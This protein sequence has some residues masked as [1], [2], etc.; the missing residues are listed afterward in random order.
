MATV[1]KR[2]WTYKGVTKEKWVLNYTDQ[3]GQR[4]QETFEK[5]KDADA[6]RVEVE[7]QMVKGSHTA[8]R[9]SVTFEFACRE[10]LKDVQR[11][12]QLGDVTGHGLRTQL[13]RGRVCERASFYRKLLVDITSNDIQDFVDDLR[14]SYSGHY[15]SGV[16]RLVSLILKF[17]CHSRREWLRANVL[18]SDPV[19]LPKYKKRVAV[20]SKADLQKLFDA[21]RHRQEGETLNTFVNR[22]AF[23]AIAALGGLRPGE[24][25]GLQWENI[26][27][28]KNILHV[29]NSQSRYDGLKTPKTESGVRDVPLSQP[30]I[31]ALQEVAFY[32]HLRDEYKAWEHYGRAK[33]NAFAMSKFLHRR[34]ETMA[35]A[36]MA[37]RTGYVFLNRDGDPMD[38]NGSVF[39]W[40][41]LMQKAGLY[42]KEGK[43][44][45]FTMHALRHA[46]ASLFIDF[47]LPLMNVSKL[48]GHANVS[49][50]TNVYGHLFPEDRRA[51]EVANRIAS[52][53]SATR[54]Q[55]ERVTH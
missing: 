14:A 2:P 24:V 22:K 21:T 15:V 47:G 42:D 10:Y 5:R 19:T 41:T 16:F 49:T 4:R 23:V 52:A 31:S 37:P 20:P 26:D 27:F 51:E 3:T 11:R 45:R 44:N 50:T 48:I 28:Q 40:R 7:G 34:W 35:E 12:C 55:Q 29:C 6:R 54:E 39:F 53:F 38:A 33:D 17:A 25:F 36:V 30:I 1:R 32:W 18:T 8:K 46:G 43:K 9:A 13:G